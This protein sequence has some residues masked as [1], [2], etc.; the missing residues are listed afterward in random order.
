LAARVRR[1]GLLRKSL[2]TLKKAD[3][4][5]RSKVPIRSLLGSNLYDSFRRRR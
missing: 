2:W 3:S 5:F 1:T 4:L